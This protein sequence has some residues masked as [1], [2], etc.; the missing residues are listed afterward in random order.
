MTAK[1]IRELSPEEVTTKLR[2]TRTELLQLRLRR[3][4]GQVEKTHQLHALRKDIARLLTIAREKPT[5]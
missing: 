3:H 2:D 1:E 4:T 5:K